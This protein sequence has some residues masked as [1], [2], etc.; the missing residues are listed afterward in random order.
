MTVVTYDL[1]FDKKVDLGA[2]AL[3]DA[4]KTAP[5]D[6]DAVLQEARQEARMVLL[7]AMAAPDNKVE[8]GA[9]ALLKHRKAPTE[10]DAVTHNEALQDARIVLGAFA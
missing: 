2:I 7:G 4:R 1:D 5:G 10:P 6:R 8:G 3:L 9:T